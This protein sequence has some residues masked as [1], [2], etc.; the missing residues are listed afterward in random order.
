MLGDEVVAVEMAFDALGERGDPAVGVLEGVSCEER[1]ERVSG[2]DS[3]AT[4]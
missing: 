1:S 4:M 3:E 2:G